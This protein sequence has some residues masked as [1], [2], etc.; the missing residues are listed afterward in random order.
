M[1]IEEMDTPT[2]LYLVMELV[3]VRLKRLFFLILYVVVK[4]EKHLGI[5]TSWRHNQIR[6]QWQPAFLIMQILL[7]ITY[8]NGIDVSSVVIRLFTQI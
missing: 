7:S 8:I 5:L 3:K 6:F 1:L 2:E 4:S